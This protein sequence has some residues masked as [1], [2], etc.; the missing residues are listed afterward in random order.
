MFKEVLQSV[1]GYEIEK[2]YQKD[3]DFHITPK[4]NKYV[5]L[6]CKWTRDDW[7]SVACGKPYNYFNKYEL[8]DKCVQWCLGKGYEVTANKPLVPNDEGITVINFWVIAYI[9]KLNLGV[10]GDESARVQVLDR[11]AVSIKTDNYADAIF[12]ATEWVHKAVYGE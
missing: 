5:G 6:G 4:N 1:L 10:Y 2:I 3:Y 12:R 9:F 11:D 8:A 7:G